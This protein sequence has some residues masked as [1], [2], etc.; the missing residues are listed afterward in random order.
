MILENATWQS[1]AAGFPHVT[2]SAKHADKH[3]YGAGVGA[4]L[5]THLHIYG[6]FGSTDSLGKDTDWCNVN[7]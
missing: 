4:R 1:A 7:V 3:F 5:L 2:S 6:S